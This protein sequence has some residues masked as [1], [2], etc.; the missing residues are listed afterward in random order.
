[1]LVRDMLGGGVSVPWTLAVSMAIGVWLM[2]T[3]LTLGME[4]NMANAEHL[5]GSL[6]LTVSVTAW[7][8]VARAVR[9]LNVP[10]GLALIAA[11]FLFDAP[12]PEAV[13]DMLLGVALIVLSLPRGRIRQSYG[14]WDRFIR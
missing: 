13:L 2:L 5:V 9:F 10:L 6:V 8:E 7:A 14:E 12:Y 3:R 4:A 1:V 11:P